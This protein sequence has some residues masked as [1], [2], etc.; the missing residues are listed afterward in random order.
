MS[1]LTG[2]A[3]RLRAESRDAERL[4]WSR[5]R[6]H[7]L[8]GWKFKRQQPVGRYIVD[9]VC[10]DAK[11]VI[12]LDGGQHADA[13][14]EDAARHAWLGSQGCRVLRFWNN[15]VLSNLDGVFMTI[16]AQLPPSPQPSPTRG[17]GVV[18][19]ALRGMQP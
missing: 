6:A 10:F 11:L 14:D 1:M 9:F 4:V 7:R 13:V 16:T 2:H 5:L 8:L 18:N 3:K 15:D 12:E 17:E 19:Q